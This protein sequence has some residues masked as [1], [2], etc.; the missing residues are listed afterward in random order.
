LKDW[1]APL[2]GSIS[3]PDS[4]SRYICACR[5]RGNQQVVPF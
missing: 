3:S 1:W 2:W 4:I 5:S